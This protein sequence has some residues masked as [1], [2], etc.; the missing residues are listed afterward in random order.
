VFGFGLN[1][2]RQEEQ[3]T[4]SF[5]ENLLRSGEEALLSGEYQ[6][7]LKELEIAAFGL[8]HRKSSA[9]KAYLLMSLSSYHLENR[10]NAEKFLKDAAL[11]VSE[12]ELREIDLNIKDVDRDVLEGLIPDAYVVDSVSKEK[13]TSI[14]DK[15][16]Q[17]KREQDKI[18]Q[19]KI[20]QD[21]IDQ[22]KIEQDKI[23]QAKKEKDEILVEKDAIKKPPEI[24]KEEGTE[25]EGL[26]ELFILNEPV[27]KSILSEI[28][29][30][31]RINTINIGILFQP[32]S[33]HQTF[34]IVDALPKRIV[35]DISDIKGI[36]AGRS[37]A[38]NDFG[39]TSIRTGMYK[40]NVARIVFDA[41][42]DI[43]TYRIE[44]TEGGLRVVI[45]KSP[46]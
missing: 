44:K 17:D 3:S 40:F 39:I 23:E 37:I 16:E 36:K 41:V 8:F 20:E 18:D 33:Q 28:R 42:G 5:Y 13:P 34:E 21:K 30:Q 43:P 7:A 32:Y 45:E 38:V 6:R 19:A 10:E 24:I 25:I 22:A 46:L 15:K 2:F 11:L 14:Q 1:D 27:Q 29:I 12:E 35:I 31:K 26:E 9:A 4:S